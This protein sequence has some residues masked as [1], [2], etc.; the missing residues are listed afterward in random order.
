MRF[1]SEPHKET[2][3][4]EARLRDRGFGDVISSPFFQRLAGVSFLA[5][6]DFVYRI[7]RPSSR[8][9][10]TIGVASLALDLA[11]LL[12]LN[13]ED[14][15]V[16][17]LANLL[18]DLGHA[19]FSHNSEPFLVEKKN[20]YHK[21]LLSSY[22]RYNSDL[23]PGEFAYQDLLAGR[24]EEV[25]LRIRDLIVA[26]SRRDLSL[27]DLFYSPLNCDKLDGN[28][29]TA[30][31][32]H[33]DHTAPS[34]MLHCFVMK[35]S[36]AY[37]LRDTVVLASRFW[38]QEKDLYWRHIYTKEV[39]AAEAMITKALEFVFDSPEKINRFVLSTDA[40]AFDLLLEHPSA[41]ILATR[42]RDGRYL[43]ALSQ[44]H[45]ALYEDLQS[46]R[47][48]IRFD[49]AR[50]L[51]VESDI[52]KRIGSDP[53]LT[54]THFSLRKYFD[55]QPS[56]LLQLS[57]FDP[58]PSIIELAELKKALATSKVS[59]DFFEVFHANPAE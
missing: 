41:A 40:E 57:L 20:M 32:L 49:K 13:D 46:V 39:F 38:E 45:P 4:A 43:H 31:L 54:I 42:I 48:E 11:D 8:Y 35:D 51:A 37:L 26:K 9:D 56:K 58:D 25:K 23:F 36:A 55:G 10:H 15:E 33:Q 28:A 18:H 7:Q 14:S 30:E 16:L 47:S 50:R 53:R 3:V 34:E 5:T 29:R 6:L 2:R 27:F 21:G 17:I 59:G 1:C 22:L 24:S 44:T 19:P 52:A 12:K